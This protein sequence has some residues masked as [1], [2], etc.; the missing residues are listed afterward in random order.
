MAKK[1]LEWARGLTI[2]QQNIGE[3]NCMELLTRFCQTNLEPG[4]V[5][6]DAE[7]KIPDDRGGRRGYSLNRDC[8]NGI[9][10]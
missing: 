5:C 8:V 4:T 9:L 2:E 1:C 6:G 10:C 3:K 7:T